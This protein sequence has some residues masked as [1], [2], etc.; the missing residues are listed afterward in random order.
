MLAKKQ[1]DSLPSTYGVYLFKKGNQVLYIG[2]S[3][4]IKTRVRSHWENARLDKK[5]N[6]IISQATTVES[7][8]SQSEFKALILESQLI[9]KYLPKYNVIWKD[10]KNFLYIKI[11]VKEKFPKVLLCRKENDGNSLYFG[12][13]S[14]TRIA[15]TLIRDIRQIIPFCTQKKVT[16]N[17]CFY[18]KIGLCQPCPNYVNQLKNRNLFI[19]EKRNYRS[20]IKK[21]IKILTGNISSLTKN[22][23]HQLKTLTKRELF[24]EAIKVRNKIFRLEKLI[25][26]RFFNEDLS[27]FNQNKTIKA[28]LE[29]ISDYFPQPKKISRI[30]GYDISN[31]GEKEAVGSLVV[32][33]NG[34]FDKNE[35]RRFKIKNIKSSSDFSRL[36]EILKR[37]FKQPWPDPDL[38]VVDGGRP[39]LRK[40]GKTMKKINKKIPLI[41]IAKNPDRL[42]IGVNGWPTIR[43]LKNNLGLNLIQLIRDESHR[44]A[45]K[46]HLFLRERDF[47]V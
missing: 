33:Q 9:K 7:I 23:N 38:I 11:T 45:R 1:I 17:P 37:R 41:G 42:V 34:I 19:K 20:N 16:K 8:P 4:N 6:L 21:V 12:P 25:H 30:E 31:L 32:F 27:L 22:L 28:L 10:N 15:G 13:F 40:I 5:E 47:L 3:I 44:F 2:K 46:Y 39:Q 43:A 35:Y 26:P 14:S 24:E 29:L 18:S 36:E